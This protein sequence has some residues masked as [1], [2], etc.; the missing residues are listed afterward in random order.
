MKT[1]TKIIAIAI[2]LSIFNNAKAQWT[3]SF[4]YLYN[5]TENIGIGTT[6]PGQLLQVSG[7]NI[8]VKTATKGYMIN[9]TLAL[10]ILNT[11]CF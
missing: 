4:P 9:D 1:T 5:T 10:C 7:G 6:T 8:D 2:L 11:N 3:N